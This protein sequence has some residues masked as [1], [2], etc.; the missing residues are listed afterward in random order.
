MRSLLL[1]G[2][3][4][5]LPTLALAQEGK[6]DGSAVKVIKIERKDPV[7]FEKDVYP[8][9]RAKCTV[10]HSGSQKEGK[11]DLDSYEGL[12]KG[13][14]RGASVKPGKPDESLLIIS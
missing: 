8:V 10:C 3:L 1:F 9:L 12:M 11:L 14:K 4:A 6:I 2:L 7:T 13:G 5:A